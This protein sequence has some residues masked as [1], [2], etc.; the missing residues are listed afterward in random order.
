MPR[1]SDG[2]RA[3]L[4]RAAEL[5]PVLRALQQEREQGADTAIT[6]RVVPADEAARRAF[7][8][9]VEQRKPAGA[10]LPFRREA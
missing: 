4:L 5:R 6:L 1:L 2:E 9:R 8:A 7:W 10:V 3:W